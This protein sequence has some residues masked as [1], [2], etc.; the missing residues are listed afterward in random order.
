MIRK[1][2]TGRKRWP[3]LILMIALVVSLMPFNALSLKTFAQ[4]AERGQETQQEAETQVGGVAGDTQPEAETPPMTESTTQP[5]SEQTT[6]S[7]SEVEISTESELTA[8]TEPETESQPEMKMKL[9]AKANAE[10]GAEVRYS[11]DGGTTWTEASLI[12]AI[13]DCYMAKDSQIELLRDIT[14]VSSEGGNWSQ[15]QI[16]AFP[17][18]SLTIDGCGHTL[19]RGEGTRVMCNVNQ[20]GSTVT[21]KNI[22]VDGGAVWDSDDPAT[23]TNSGLSFSGNDHLF[24][25]YDGGT[26]I[27]E[28]GTVLQN[29]D[30]I[31]T[32]KYG[33]AISVAS[34]GAGTLIMND[35]AVIKDN[36]VYTG[37]VYVWPEGAFIMN[38]GTIS[39]NYG[40]NN[41][42][43]VCMGGGTFNMKGGMISGNKAGAG[44]GAVSVFASDAVFNM[45]GGTISNNSINGSLGGGVLVY[46]G[47][48][49]VSGNPVIT[50]NTAKDGEANNAY[51]TSGKTIEITNT[52]TAGAFIGVTTQDVPSTGNPVSVAIGN[53]DFKGFFHGDSG[54]EISG[55]G[56]NDVQFGVHTVHEW[57]T[58][59]TYDEAGHWHDC[60]KG[61]CGITDNTQKDGYAVHTYTDT[62][63]AP[64]CTE[65]G[66]TTHA[67]DTCEY[68][69]TDTPMDII[70]HTWGDWETVTEATCTSKG[71]EKRVCTA[72]GDIETRE[73]DV[74]LHN[75]STDWKQ[76]E[77]NHWHEC[78][79][80]DKA[81]IAPHAYGDW[82]I[83]K[84]TTE[85]EEGSKERICADCD[86]KETMVIPMTAH[87]HSYSIDW[88]TDGTTHWHECAC[89]DKADVAAHTYGDWVITKEATATEDGAKERIC[90]VCGYKETAVIPKMVHTH[91]YGTD[92]K[93][94]GTNH[95][96]ECACGA[97]NEIASHTFKW[98]IDKEA[99]ATEKGKKHEECSVC[100]YKKAEVEIEVTGKTN[101]TEGPRTGDNS[102]IAFWM[103]LFLLSGTA[104]VGLSCMAAYG[105]KRRNRR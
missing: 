77:T 92:W 55:D 85:T 8:E 20:P 3:S 56:T 78:V 50:D 7:A 25:V 86:Y 32:N 101:N 63:T 18:A 88:K 71:S 19:K 39:G 57:S 90:T 102:N 33:G 22:V 35:G 80:G 69:Y 104:L 97:K 34:S 64:T 41:G 2:K 82:V 84:E 61:G 4:E 103:S 11:T 27:L 28:S 29:N 62:V 37:A 44:G 46:G 36:T 51:L 73:I 9:R 79:C 59:W 67:C 23:R 10:E 52:L 98:V 72:C 5:T 94:D 105:R 40:M 100:G 76:D 54:Y 16:L 43:A 66:Y 38:G 26:L 30:L 99:T 91:S 17:D 58:E 87:V 65:K 81:D 12:D 83:T 95:W 45:T 31:G 48:M 24:T 21:L 6:E 47:S 93:A 60:K 89:G 74:I 70:P 13:Y 1:D 53:H 75:Y 68:S 14:L 42:G 96:H 15:G 49:T